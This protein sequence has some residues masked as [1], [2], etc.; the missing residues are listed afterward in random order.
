MKSLLE[1]TKFNTYTRSNLNNLSFI[2]DTLLANN[3]GVAL[4]RPKIFCPNVGSK[5]CP[6]RQYPKNNILILA[7]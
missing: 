4:I 2:F 6:K 1:L 3:A 5:K 7:R